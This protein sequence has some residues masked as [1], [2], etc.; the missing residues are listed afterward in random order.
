MLFD[1]V[2]FTNGVVNAIILSIPEHEEEVQA[3]DCSSHPG[4]E[5][6]SHHA[7]RS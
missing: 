4:Q 5:V 3:D 2:V 7:I 1:P 6:P